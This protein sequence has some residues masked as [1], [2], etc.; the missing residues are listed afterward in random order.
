MLVEKLVD[1]LNTQEIPNVASMLT[2]FNR[3]LVS[4][5]TQ[6][7]RVALNALTLPMETEVLVEKE[8][9]IRVS[10]TMFYLLLCYYVFCVYCSYDL[11]V[12]HDQSGRCKFQVRALKLL[13]N[14]VVG[15]NS[16]ASLEKELV[17][18]LDRE[19]KS[20]STENQAMSDKVCSDLEAK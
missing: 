9:E 20:K 7:Y 4:K 14:S 1:A 13:R 3:D 2:V 17:E 8:K 6:S 5:G 12:S 16:E 18:N 10:I 19:L 15:R 11:E